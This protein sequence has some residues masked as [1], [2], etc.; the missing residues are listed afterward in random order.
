MI[1]LD[2][3]RKRQNYSLK[4]LFG[5][6]MFNFWQMG[7]IYFMGPALTVNGRTPLPINMDNLTALIAVSYVVSILIMIFLPSRVVWAERMGTMAALMTMLGL[8][9]P[10][11]DR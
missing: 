1:L 10:L 11:P 4:K 3:Q 6:A 8:F 9:L 2:N 5:F 7:F